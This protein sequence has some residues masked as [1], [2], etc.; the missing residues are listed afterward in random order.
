MTAQERPVGLSPRAW[1]GIL[2]VSAFLLYLL[3]GILAEKRQTPADAYYDQLAKAFLAGRVDIPIT[4]SNYD[5][6]EYEGR[7]YVPFPP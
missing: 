5:L 4:T 2:F 7:W 1:F 6:T 3:P